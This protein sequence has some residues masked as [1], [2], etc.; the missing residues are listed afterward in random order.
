MRKKKCKH[1]KS[2]EIKKN[3]QK[4]K[5]MFTFGSDKVLGRG[6]TDSRNPNSAIR[7]NPNS[8]Q[9][10]QPNT[11]SILSDSHTSDSSFSNCPSTFGVFGFNGLNPELLAFFANQSFIGYQACSILAQNWLM[12]K[13]CRAPPEDALKNGYEL[14]FSE[15]V[16][17][18]V[19]DKIDSVDKITDI[20]KYLLNAEYYRRVYGLSLA[21]FK[22]DYKDK[23]AYEKPFNIDNVREGSYIGIKQVDPSYVSPI[24]TSRGLTDPAYI[25]YFE[26]EFWLI[27][28]VQYHKSHFYV[29]RYAPVTDILKSVYL[30]GGKPLVEMAAERVYASEQSMNES[31]KLLFTKRLK[32]VKT[33]MQSQIGNAEF[34]EKM[35]ILSSFA[36]NNGVYAVDNNE[37]VQFL[38]TDLAGIDDIAFNQYQMVAAI[39]W[40]PVTRLLGTSPKGFNATGEHEIKQYYDSLEVIQQKIYTPILRKHYDILLRSLGKKDIETPEIIWNPLMSPSEKELSEIRKSNS[41]TDRNNFEMG[42]IDSTEIRRKLSEDENS[43]YNNIEI[44]D[45]SELEETKEVEALE[46]GE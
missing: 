14:N 15:E 41:E 36:D 10:K 11:K 28:G 3:I 4:N 9:I 38:D 40:M 45:K 23:K 34:Q 29:S 31:P 13:I 24:L 5:T 21:L 44:V 6:T 8:F 2:P 32:L 16:D 7:V 30:Y 43:G 39:A 33:D 42:V 18:K 27:N 26:P 19:I 22:V 37:D 17:Q 12:D 46:N 1:K 20:N 25:N 35:Q